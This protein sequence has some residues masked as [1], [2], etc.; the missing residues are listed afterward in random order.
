MHQLAMH[1]DAWVL[2]HAHIHT[3]TPSLVFALSS[4]ESKCERCAVPVACKGWLYKCVIGSDESRKWTNRY[5]TLRGPRLAFGKTEAASEMYKS[6]TVTKRCVRV[7]AYC[8]CEKFPR[9]L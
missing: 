7:I 4:T 9:P 6:M 5:F 3:H 8:L 1:W 2:I